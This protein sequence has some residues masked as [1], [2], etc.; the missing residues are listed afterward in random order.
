MSFLQKFTAAKPMP[1]GKD[2]SFRQIVCL[3]GAGISF[4]TMVVMLIMLAGFDP[5]Y[6][7][8]SL[9]FG[10]GSVAFYVLNYLRLMFE[11]KSAVV[12]R[13]ADASVYLLI[14]ATYAP[15]QLIL[16]RQA[17]WDNNT[18][19]AG[20][21][22]FGLTAFVCAFF[23]IAAL[24]SQRKFRMFGGFMFIVAA[25]SLLFC[26]RDLM[27]ALFAL[28]VVALVLMSVAILAF[29]ATPILFWFFDKKT[30]PMKVND[31]LFVVAT[32]ASSVL[33]L[34]YVFLCR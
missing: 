15:L 4:A 10:L 1:E 16:T 30:W 2:K 32:I 29:A 22:T 21:L 33:T 31:V 13:F 17:L 14:T 8:A 11:G 34:L 27:N 7:A 28:P 3:V 18:I 26:A 24:C 23:F 19:L 5:T 12:N 20:W 6:V 25:F 9:L